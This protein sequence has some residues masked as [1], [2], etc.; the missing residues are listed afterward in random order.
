MTR[1]RL[2]KVKMPKTNLH[3]YRVITSK[4]EDEGK[5]IRAKYE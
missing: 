4:S 5:D 3:F 1:Q 2:S